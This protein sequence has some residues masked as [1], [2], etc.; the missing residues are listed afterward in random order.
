MEGR[1]VGLSR[2]HDIC[3]PVQHDVQPVFLRDFILPR[4]F[5][6]CLIDPEPQPQYIFLNVVLSDQVDGR[7]SLGQRE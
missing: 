6:G 2:F 4:G 3:D 7:T 5:H 1:L